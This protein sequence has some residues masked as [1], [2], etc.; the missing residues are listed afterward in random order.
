M[1]TDTKATEG[2][3]WQV[4]ARGRMALALDRQAQREQEAQRAKRE[5]SMRPGPRPFSILKAS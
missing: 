5:A 1:D 2:P 4:T 3:R